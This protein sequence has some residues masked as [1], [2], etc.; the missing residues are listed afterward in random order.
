MYHE[1]NVTLGINYTS[2]KGREKK[3]IEPSLT[4]LYRVVGKR[5]DARIKC[6]GL[7]SNCLLLTIY[8]GAILLMF[9][10]LGFQICKMGRTEPSRASREG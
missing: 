8:V 7:K 5:D 10:T 3:R 9:L 6:L 2:V 1:T 4:L